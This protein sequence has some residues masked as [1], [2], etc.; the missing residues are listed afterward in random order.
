MREQVKQLLK[1]SVYRTIGETANGLGAVNGDE[2]TLRVLMYHKVND[3]PSNR[4]SMPVSLFDE[5][6][7]QL[8]ELGYEAVGLDAVIDHYVQDAP[9]PRGAVLITFDDG[10]RDNL[11]NAAPVLQRHGY[12]AVQ[13]VPLAY[14]GTA[15]PLPHERHLSANGV[16]NPTVDWDEIREL[17][18]YGVRVESHGI[19]HKPLAE[20]EI[21][22]AARE[23]TI[24]KLKLEERLGRPVRA[25]SYVKGSEADY[26]PVQHPM[27]V[28]QAG[29]DL[30]FTAVSGANG[31][32]SDPLQLRRYNVEPYSHRTFELVLA[33]ACDL[34]SMKDTVTGT[35]ARRLFNAALGTSSP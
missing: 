1:N 9:L 19:S 29:Y 28:R 23:I 8:K 30:A 26:K 4:M 7:A 6:M 31:P 35:Y 18:R 17:E 34:I 20:L 21:D 25:F 15:L 5:Q 10:Y 12:P 13:F 16:H 27:L 24:S 11:L 33:G 22:E 3:L 14:V 2:R 32:H